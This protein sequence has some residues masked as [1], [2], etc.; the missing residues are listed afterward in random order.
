MMH[1]ALFTDFYELTMAQGFWKRGYNGHRVVFDY[2]FR[3]QP[4]SG[5]YSVFA[6]LDTL[7]DAL[8]NFRF[9]Q[10]DL[11]YL[12]SLGLFDR[13]F[14][15]FLSSFRFTGTIYAAK[16]GEIVF[17]QEPLVRVEANLLQ[18]QI[19][20]GVV[21]NTINFQNLIATKSAR[22]WLASGRGSIMEFGLRRAQGAD[23]ALSAARA[24]YIGGAYGTSN[25]IAGKRFGIPVL[26][27]MAHSWVMSYP[28]ELEAFRT[29][30]SIYPKATVFL[31]DTYNTLESGTTN[32][33]IAGKEL[34]AQ[35]HTFGVRLD[36]GDIDYLT[37][38]VRRKLDEAGCTKATITVS[39]DLDE[40][41]IEHLVASKAPIDTWGVGTNLVTGGNDAAFTGVYKLSAIQEGDGFRPVM[42]ISDNP[43]KTTNPGIK[44]LYRIYNENGL[45]RLDIITVNDESP[46]EGKPVMAYHPS[47]DYRQLQIVPTKVETLLSKVFEGGA[48]VGTAPSLKESQEYFKKRISL[49]DS[50]YLRQLNPHVYK[51][52]ISGRLRDMKLGIISKNQSTRYVTTDSELGGR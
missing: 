16:E 48:R 22:V 26:G 25:T 23:G 21:L 12:E 36:S 7:L 10:D 47:G 51:V 5:G 33:I 39:N 45:P 18:A 38:E 29:Y 11:A 44:E 42:K 49:F 43:E 17:P 14:L 31:I 46:E 13:G 52:S 32:A 24:A 8:E 41:I 3:R 50:T 30:A 19:I 15:D 28:T 40:G 27:T 35:G 20:E 1:N 37:R 6:G 9:T 2:F 4:F 34:E